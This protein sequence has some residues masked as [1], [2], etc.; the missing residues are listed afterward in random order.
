M[1]P[2]KGTQVDWGAREAGRFSHVEET[3]QKHTLV[4]HHPEGCLQVAGHPA[5]EQQ[6]NQNFL[7]PQEGS[8]IIFLSRE[9][10]GAGWKA[11][12]M[13]CGKVTPSVSKGLRVQAGVG[14]RL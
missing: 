12:Q 4:G 9:G 11:M 6:T 2:G 5:T 13:P 14:G 10:E 3:E 1:H 8:V 7:W